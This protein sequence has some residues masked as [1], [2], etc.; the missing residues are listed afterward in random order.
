MPVIP[1]TLIFILTLAAAV[2]FFVLFIQSRRAYKKLLKKNLREQEEKFSFSQKVDFSSIHPENHADQ[3]VLEKLCDLL[4]NEKVYLDP[5][6]SLSQLAKRMGTNRTTVSHVVN[7]YFQQTLPAL[8]NYYRVNEAIRLLSDEATR[9]NK[10]EV[11][12]EMCGYQNR[13]VFHSAFKRETGITPKHFRRV[14]E[15]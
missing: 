6:L 12:G 4:E 14:S 1:C 3:L 10:L 11:I 9:D 15:S 13:Q 8:I 5:N 2:V 7:R